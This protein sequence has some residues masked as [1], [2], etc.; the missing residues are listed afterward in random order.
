MAGSEDELLPLSGLQHLVY[1]ERQ[2]ALIHVET[3]WTENVWTIE[4]RQLHDKVTSGDR[5]SR[6]DLRIVRDAP[7]RSLRLG[8]TG[9]ADVVE[10]HRVHVGG[11]GIPLPRTVGRWRPFPVEYKRGRPKRHRADEIQVCAQAL[12]L[13]EM[14][15]IAVEGGALFYGQPRRRC[16]VLFSHELRT[17]TEGT[18][19]RFREIVSTGTTPAISYDPGR[20]DE[21]SL[22]E[23]CCPKVV[24]R[25]ARQYLR[26]MLVK[27]KEHAQR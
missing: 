8:L 1:C 19:R 21:C 22:R 5:E 3:I 4:G 9:R 23:A 25:D 14:L 26:E 24:G 10:F 17:L 2:A 7:I 20:C 27:D 13:E 6:G 18:A 12:C 16:D 15:D 11:E